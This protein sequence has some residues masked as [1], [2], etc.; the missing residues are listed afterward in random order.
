MKLTVPRLKRLAKAV[1]SISPRQGESLSAMLHRRQPGF[2]QIIDEVGLDPRCVQAHRF[3]SVF[4]ALALKHA[5]EVAGCRLPRYPK[6]AIR[7][8]ACLIAQGQEAQ[9]GRRACGNPERIRRH[10]LIRGYFDEDDTRWLCTTIS[11]FL[12]TVER[13]L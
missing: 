10:L 6:A 9:I 11:A 2:C 7:E 8:A 5:E 4:C 13:S 3:C 1:R 12:F